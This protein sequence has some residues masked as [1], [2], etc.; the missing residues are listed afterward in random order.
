VFTP[1]DEGGRNLQVETVR[2]QVLPFAQFAPFEAKHAFL[3]FPDADISF[4]EAHPEAANA[5]L[6]TLEEPRPG[7]HFVLLAER[8]DHLLTTIRSRC[9]RVRFSPL[10][11]ATVDGIL[12]RAGVAPELRTAAVA[13]AEGRAD[14]A[15]VLAVEGAAD[16]LLALAMRVDAAAAGGRAGDIVLVAEEVAKFEPLSLALEALSRYYRDVAAAGLGIGDEHLAFRHRAAE[17]RARAEHLPPARAANAC[18]LLRQLDEHLAQNANKEIA[19]GAL[20][21]SI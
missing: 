5:L 4:P 12:E 11:D 1:R 15:S 13:L 21:S 16:A 8:P 10:P 19:L 18:A 14:R 9:Q 17:I 20:I 2:E 7:V 3:I 6:K